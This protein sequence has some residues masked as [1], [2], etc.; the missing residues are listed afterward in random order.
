MANLPPTEVRFQVE[1]LAGDDPHD[2]NRLLTHLE[3]GQIECDINGLVFPVMWPAHRAHDPPI[4]E[5]FLHWV[6]WDESLSSSKQV[7]LYVD[8]PPLFMELSNLAH[9]LHGQITMVVPQIPLGNRG[10][11]LVVVHQIPLV[12]MLELLGQLSQQVRQLERRVVDL[13]A[14]V[15]LLRNHLGI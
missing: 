15:Q 11:T 5:L 3:L 8:H 6:P 7:H 13:E 2:L 1:F 9:H 10:D 4:T 14:T 12:L